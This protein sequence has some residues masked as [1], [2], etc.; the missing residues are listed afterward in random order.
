MTKKKNKQV[1][2][3]SHLKQIK[4]V[5]NPD[6]WDTLSDT[7]KKTWSTFMINR[8][9]SM[10][11]DWIDTIAEV[12]PYIQQ[13][14]PETVYRF[15]SDLIP[16]GKTYLKYVKGKKSNNNYEDWLVDLICLEYQCSSREAEDY[17]EILYSTKNGKK[18]IKSI[19]EKWGTEKK[20]ITKLKLKV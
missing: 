6:Y 12:Q 13:L 16:K 8:Y 11:I 1:N 20:K 15:Y 5:Q 9:L 2:L 19:C 3:F 7:E 10:N 17:L 14:P 4:E 18:K